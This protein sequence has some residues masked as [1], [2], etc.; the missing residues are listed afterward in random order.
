MTPSIAR[1]A[2]DRVAVWLLAV[3][4]TFGYASLLYAFGAILQPVQEATGWSK[5][6][7]AGAVTL[8]LVLAAAVSPLAGRLV[9]RGFG[10]E[11]LVGGAITGGLSLLAVSQAR[12]LWHW[13]LAWAFVGPAMTASLYEA[14]FAFLTRRLG[15]LARPAIIRVTL[16]GGLAS[17][18]AFPLG[19]WIAAHG[20][21]RWAYAG[22][23]ALELF[24]TAPAFWIAG[25][26]LR[27]SDRLG[28]ISARPNPG[29]VRRAMRR[30][31]FW[32][33]AIAFGMASLNHSLLST[34]FI[35]VFTGLG[36]GAGL[37]VAAA[38]TVGPFQVA[39][40]FILMLT[41][42]RAPVLGATWLAFGLLTASSALLWGAGT[43]IRLIFGFAV[44]QGVG[45]G[46][47]SILRPLLIAE[48]L[49]TENFG[50]VSGALAIVPLLAT[51]AAPA[52]GAGLLAT[53]GA[54]LAAAA[55]LAMGL[56]GLGLTLALRSRR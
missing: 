12:E 46:I 19:A 34:Y 45:I 40:R 50:A 18:L 44:L 32:L 56:A 38:A 49:G 27:R 7:L 2:G 28:G 13:Y 53:G 26:L 15:P 24:G 9:D 10:A 6:A 20:G 43:E 4:V 39:G 1:P 55:T 25:R 37:A 54:M 48:V 36:A 21:W 22:F 47:I 30:P 33:I 35:P 16:V 14:S 17:T 8:A 5:P 52:L 42:S 3:G 41:G 29:A 31:A 11:L 51:A 23:A